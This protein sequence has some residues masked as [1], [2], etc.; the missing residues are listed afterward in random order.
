MGCILSKREVNRNNLI[1]RVYNVDENG[2]KHIPGKIEVT[3]TD[4]VL[5]QKGHEQITWPLRC[6]RRYGWEEE[7]F[8]FESGRRCCTG[9]GIYAFNCK[10]AELL[11]RA[12]QESILRVGQGDISSTRSF[13]HHTSHSNSRPP[14]TI[15]MNDL[16][17][18]SVPNGNSGLSRMREMNYVNQAIVSEHEQHGYEN[19]TPSGANGNA[20]GAVDTASAL[21]D[22]LHSKPD[23]QQTDPKLNY[24]D[25]DFPTSTESLTNLNLNVNNQTVSMR[26]DQPTVR[27]RIGSEPE[28][29]Y[30]ELVVD[31]DDINMNE[32]FDQDP[33]VDSDKPV[34]YINIGPLNEAQK[35]ELRPNIPQPPL[36]REPDY[37]NVNPRNVQPLVNPRNTQPMLNYI[38]VNPKPS[39][40]SGIVSPVSI[41]PS[42]SP[43]PG[44]SYAEI[45]FD[46]T[47][48]L[49]N[50]QVS[51]EDEGS[52]KTR[53]NSS[54]SNAF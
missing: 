10:R 43:T 2:V 35:Q 33:L 34:D 3:D 7:L 20:P 4:L 31:C 46:R 52:R 51:E 45:D 23:L 15:E 17:S 54:I 40:S 39:S 26:Q 14:S 18:F 42:L 11:F 6:L 1:F 16:M 36:I 38:Q 21:I 44:P 49:S 37:T 13:N 24:I 27:R 48:A 8:S 41:V 12:V 5:R 53:H 22:F 32:V 47:T 9:P 30:P 28:G 29:R 25:P 19:V 50:R